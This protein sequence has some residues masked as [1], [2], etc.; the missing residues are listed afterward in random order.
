MRRHIGL[1]IGVIAAVLVLSAAATY[2][3]AGII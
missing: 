1:V 3:I 2:V